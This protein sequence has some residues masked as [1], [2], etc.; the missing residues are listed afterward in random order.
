MVIEG[1]V[2]FSNVTKHDEYMGQSTGRFTMT[3]TMPQDSAETLQGKGVKIKTY[4]PEEGDALLQ[5]KFASKYPVR[6]VSADGEVFSG[7]IPRGSLVRI[8]YKL[9]QEHPVHG[10]AT[11]M[12]AIK[13]LEVAEGFDDGEDGDDGDF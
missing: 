13:V 6:V 8:K 9:G 1:N 5:R 2:A 12:E 11:Y 10:V 7:E 4:Q 3:I